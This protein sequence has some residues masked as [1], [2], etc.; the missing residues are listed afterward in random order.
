[1]GAGVARQAPRPAVVE[2]LIGWDRADAWMAALEGI[3]HLRAH[4]PDH[5]RA[6][7]LASS[8]QTFLYVCTAPGGRVV[9][10]VAL[11]PVADGGFDVITPLGFAGFAATGDVPDFADYWM[12]FWRERGA[13][14]AYIQLNPITDRRLLSGCLAGLAAASAPGNQ[15]YL[16]DLRPSLEALFAGMGRDHRSRLRGWRRAGEHMVADQGRLR[17]A[18]RELYPSFVARTAPA[19]VYRLGDE[20]LCALLEGPGVFLSGATDADGQIEAVSVFY[21]TP[22][23]ADYFLNA[24]TLAGRRHGRALVW[25]AIEYFKEI[26]VPV[27]NLGGGIRPADELSQ[28]KARFGAPAKPL[29]A[30]KQIFDRPAFD[31]LCHAAGQSP[32][33][34]G[35]YFPPYRA[36]SIA[37]TG[38]T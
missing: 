13:V 16:L 21:H 29:I 25:A 18:F 11:R 3:A 20:C 26:G 1:M 22:L 27:L 23:G 37:Q 33:Q 15:I 34:D 9:C 5:G 14:C 19:P 2:Q 10:P 31:R 35:S 24:A 28:F 6:M 38:T 30:I 8:E 32:L 17:A 7:A 12:A 4:G 36:P